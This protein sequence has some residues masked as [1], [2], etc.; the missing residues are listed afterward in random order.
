MRILS[1][2]F[3]FILSCYLTAQDNIPSPSAFLNNYGRQY[4]QEYKLN[5][6]YELIS[7]SSPK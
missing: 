2:Y 4:S 6:Y 7:Q 1:L 5:Q 3:F